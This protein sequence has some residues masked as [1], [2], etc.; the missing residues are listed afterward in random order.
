MLP[1]GGHFYSAGDNSHQH[2]SH[3]DTIYN[4]FLKHMSRPDKVLHSHQQKKYPER[5]QE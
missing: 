2:K 3:L 5:E 1:L 4:Y